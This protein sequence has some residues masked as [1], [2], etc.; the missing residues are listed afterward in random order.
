MP[1]TVTDNTAL[2][3]AA[4]RLLVAAYDVSVAASDTN[5]LCVAPGREGFV[6]WT[7]IY[8]AYGIALKALGRPPAPD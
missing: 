6:D 1:I 3:F 8:T 4:C 2:A 5:P 7:D